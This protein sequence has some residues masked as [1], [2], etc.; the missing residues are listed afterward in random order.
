[1]PLLDDSYDLNGKLFNVATFAQPR[2]YSNVCVEMDVDVL[3]VTSF[4]AAFDVPQTLRYTILQILIWNK[5]L[6]SNC[7]FFSIILGYAELKQV[8]S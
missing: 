8:Q 7:L 2:V 4:S 6:F 5:N 3:A 1:M